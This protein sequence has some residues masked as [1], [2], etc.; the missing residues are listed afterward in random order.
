M[1]RNAT[2][3]TKN[4]ETNKLNNPIYYSVETY[5]VCM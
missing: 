1:S 4:E 5:I 3:H 2:T